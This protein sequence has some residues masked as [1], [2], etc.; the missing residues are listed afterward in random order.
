MPLSLMSLPIYAKVVILVFFCSEYLNLV[1]SIP[2]PLTTRYLLLF[3]S[4]I[5]FLKKKFKS[6]LF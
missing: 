2:E 4:M 6:L 5:F 3:L 1:K